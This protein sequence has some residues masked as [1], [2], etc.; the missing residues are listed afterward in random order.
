MYADKIRCIHNL[1]QRECLAFKRHA[2][3]RMR[4]RNIF[5]I[6]VEEVLITG[7]IIEDYSKSKPLPCHLV[8]GYTKT[9]RP[10]HVVVGIDSTDEMIWAIT[11]YEP[12]L[13]EWKKEFKERR[14]KV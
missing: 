4:Q 13:S 11:V 2:A 7:E 6:E 10:L 8:L 12:N 9:N 5:A 3:I 14:N 1:V